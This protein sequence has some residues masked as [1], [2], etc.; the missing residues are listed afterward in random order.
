MWKSVYDSV[1]GV[2][3]KDSDLPCQDACRVIISGSDG[4]NLI[5]ACADGAGSAQHSDIGSTIACDVFVNLAQQHLASSQCELDQGTVESWYQNV[6]IELECRANELEVPVRELATTLLGV[7]VADGTSVFAQI[8]DGAIVVLDGDDYRVV[9]W[10]QSGEY[11]NTTNFLSN[12]DFIDCIAY[13]QVD[14]RVEEVAVFTDGLERLVL[15]FAEQEVYSPFLLPMLT[16]LRLSEDGQEF[17][18]PLRKFLDSAAIN[19][20]TDDDKTLILATRRLHE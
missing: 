16:Q 13:S 5:I 14:E 15:Q 2:S 10:P 1:A 11:A 17:F 6:R 3:H 20:R 19:E 12:D 8:G 7:V 4:N 18:E 9:H